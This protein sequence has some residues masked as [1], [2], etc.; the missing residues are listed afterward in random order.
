[1]KI[2]R[3]VII[4]FIVLMAFNL[5]RCSDDSS[6][7]D[8]DVKPAEFSITKVE[9]SPDVYLGHP[10]SV[11]VTIS[12]VDERENVPVI[13]NLAKETEIDDAEVSM[14]S[15]GSYIIPTVSSGVNQYQISVTVPAHS[16]DAGEYKLAAMLDPAAVISEEKEECRQS[17]DPASDSEKECYNES[18]MAPINVKLDF[19]NTPD[20]LIEEILLT[21][22]VATVTTGDTSPDF[23][24]GTVKIKSVAKGMINVPV[25]IVLEKDGVEYTM[26]IWDSEIEGY[27]NDYMIGELKNNI[28]KSIP[29]SLRVDSTLTDQLVNGENQMTIKAVIDPDNLTPEAYIEG[30]SGGETN[31]SISKQ[32]TIVKD[33][34]VVKS[35]VYSPNQKATGT[36]GLNFSK[37]FSQTFGSGTIGAFPGFSSRASLNENGAAGFTGGGVDISIFNQSFSFVRMEASAAAM[38]HKLSS[39]YCDIYLRFTTQTLYSFHIDGEYSWDKD[40]TVYKSKGYT[41]TFWASCI[42]VN[43]S[44]GAQGTMGFAV[45]F[46]VGDTLEATA[47]EFANAGAYASASVGIAGIFE[48]GVKCNLNLINIEYK[49][50]VNAGMELSDGAQQIRGQLQEQII[51]VLAGPNGSLNFFVRYPF[52]PMCYK[53]FFG[54]KWWYPCGAPGTKEDLYPIVSFS[55]WNMTIPLLDLTQDTPWINTGL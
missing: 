45:S 46:T 23:I 5:S 1:M 33:V 26:M 22:D 20:L 16:I 43:I 47:S 40:W 31:N 37:S 19:V 50:I 34:T 3:I 12:S 25:R 44:A 41:A 17:D 14:Y 52:L 8:D 21:S 13:L 39:S 27:V 11:T 2:I 55:T 28:S 24:S 29:F 30:M 53:K 7:S 48:G 42:P 18:M 4:L 32:I 51:C 38:P 6:D 36:S 54:R 49:A 9:C 35:N 10:I 15:A